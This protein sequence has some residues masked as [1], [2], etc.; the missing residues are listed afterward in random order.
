MEINNQ[1]TLNVSVQRAWALLTNLTLMARCVPGA[2]LESIEGDEH[3][4]VLEAKVGPVTARYKGQCQLV[5]YDESIH[6]VTLTA[7]GRDLRGQGNA[8]AQVVIT[9]LSITE[10]ITSVSVAIDLTI[11]GKVSHFGR[12]ALADSNSTFLRQFALQLE[13]HV[14]NETSAKHKEVEP[15]EKPQQLT[16]LP[17]LTQT[18]HSAS[19]STV[20]GHANFHSSTTNIYNHKSGSGLG[21]IHSPAP[22]LGWQNAPPSLILRPEYGVVPIVGRDGLLRDLTSWSNTE[23]QV[24]VAVVIGDGGSGKSRRMDNWSAAR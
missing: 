19:N 4:G 1:F 16:A 10:S 2:K 7:K 5:E 22:E 18:V 21:A 9:M 24:D 14:L 11:S 17:Q 23:K 6:R 12:R 8:S 15:F 3:K 13:Q 20:I